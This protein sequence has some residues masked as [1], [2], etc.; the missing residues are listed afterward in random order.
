MSAEHQTQKGYLILADITGYTSYVARTELEHAHEILTDLLELLVGRLTPV[1]TLSRLEGDAV[2]A[3]LPVDRLARAETLLEIIESTYV[4]FRDR[5]EGIRRRTTCNCRACQAIPSLDLKFI[6]NFGEFV[7]QH[8]AGIDELVGSDVN[9]LHR[10]SKNHVAEATGWRGYVLFSEQCL[11]MTSLLPDGLH[12][13]VET[14]DHLGDVRTYSMDLHPRY[15]ALTDARRTIV[16]PSEAH[17]TYT[18]DIPAGVPIV[19]DWLNDPQR[20]SAWMPGTSWQAVSRPGGRTGI[21]A[22][23]HCAHGKGETTV[24]NVLDWRPFDY[25]TVENWLSADG[26]MVAVITQRLE[27]VPGGTRLHTAVKFRLPLPA[28]AVRL[29]AKP[30]ARIAGF[31]A[32]LALMTRL[33]AAEQAPAAEPAEGLAASVAA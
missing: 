8:V 33:I 24:E 11:A 28:W 31:D 17:V 18:R 21:G 9:L 15:A 23:N 19:W 26:K 10:L 5:V 20:R 2:F 27:P 30:L 32:S 22:R 4:A 29:A 25:Y 3:Y 1:L 12:V 13:E 14:Y 6:L 16:T 7:V